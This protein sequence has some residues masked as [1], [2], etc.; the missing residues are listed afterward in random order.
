MQAE[1]VGVPQGEPIRDTSSV[2]ARLRRRPEIVLS[3]LLLVAVIA[4][5]AWVSETGIVSRLILPSPFRVFDGVLMLLGASWFPQ[6]LIATATEMVVG[7]V[8]AAVAAIALAVTLHQI[9][10]ARRVLYPY[11]VTFQVTPM[12][13]LAPVFVIWLGFGME[14]KILI[15]VTT[16]F[17]VILVTT[18]AG[19]ESVRRN[20]ILLMRSFVASRRQIFTMLELPSALPYMFAGFKTA[21]TMALIG[22]LVGEFVT[23]QAGLGRLLTQFSFAI[24]QDLVFATVFIVAALGLVM[25]GVVG[26]LQ[27]WIVW[28]RP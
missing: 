9:P 18:L 5:W 28:W 12:I 6:H 22:A 27:R 11:I 20:S 3:P 10:L 15:A 14:S 17:F 23:A 13:A 21:A 1:E 24:R 2:G 19:L 16:A 8:I 7:F 25:Y 26:L 4:A